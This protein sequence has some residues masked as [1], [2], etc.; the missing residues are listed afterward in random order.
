MAPMFWDY[1]RNEMGLKRVQI[2][3]DTFEA[4]LKWNNTKYV[5]GNH[6]TL[7][8]FSLISATICLEG[9][10]FDLSGWPKVKQWYENFKT[11]Q[12]EFWPICQETLK[13]IIHFENNT[14]DM[15][16]CNHP[17]HPKKK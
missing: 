13:W 6:V 14:P 17:I 16:K 1:P 4:Y 9:I 8:D 7:G 2:A 11:E 15:S 5:A 3:L 12:K 10:K